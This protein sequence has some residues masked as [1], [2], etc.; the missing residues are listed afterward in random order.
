M[1]SVDKTAGCNLPLPHSRSRADRDASHSVGEPVGE[2]AGN[3]IVYD[4]HVAVLQLHGLKKGDLV[5]FGVLDENEGTQKDEE[6]GDGW[7]P[8]QSADDAEELP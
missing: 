8:S 5:L 4:L 7:S 3:V 1:I 6:D 2:Q